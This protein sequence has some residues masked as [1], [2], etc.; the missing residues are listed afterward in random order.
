MKVK[1][2]VD[3]QYQ[4]VT[5]ETQVQCRVFAT[6]FNP[7]GIRMGNKILRQRLRGP[8]MAA[9][10]PPKGPTI[11]DLRKE[12]G[13]QFQFIDEDELAW[14]DHVEGYVPGHAQFSNPA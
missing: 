11:Q 8:A 7:D 1:S 13:S 9:Y 14:A 12:F 6:T 4:T 2:T 10:Y 5:D 3:R